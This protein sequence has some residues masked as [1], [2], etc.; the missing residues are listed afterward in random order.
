MSY[1]AN[2]SISAEEWEEAM[3]LLSS[4]ISSKRRSDG[5]NWAH[6]FDM[7]ASYLEVNPNMCCLLLLTLHKHALESGV[8]P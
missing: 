8:T 3:A 5:V 6:A 2:A 7:M 4:L 1:N